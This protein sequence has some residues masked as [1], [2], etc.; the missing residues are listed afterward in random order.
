MINRA[1]GLTR[2][3][4]LSE[5]K[6]RGS[7][8]T[9]ELG[10]DLGISSVA[11]RQHLSTLAAEG[12]V[13]IT[14]ERRGLGRPVHRYQLT[15]DGDETFERSY[16][17]LCIQLLE[18]IRDTQGQ[19]GVEA[20]L[21]ARQKRLGNALSSRVSGQPLETKVNEIARF[22]TRFGYMAS[23]KSNE[24]TIKLTEMNCA[25]CKVAREYPGVCAHE[26]AMMQEAAGPDV[27]VV[28]EQ[29]ILAGDPACVYSFTPKAG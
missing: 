15:E 25:V 6:Q 18:A 28:R 5:I 20:V 9:D 23:S 12:R 21:A 7:V 4:I 22:Q 17:Q 8:T 16:D 24:G 1:N 11:V 27:A 10:E 29:Y 3:A 14:V 26:L 19:E 13:A 2:H